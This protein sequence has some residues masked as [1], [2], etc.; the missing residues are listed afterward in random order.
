MVKNCMANRN[1]RRSGLGDLLRYRVHQDAQQA[2]QNSPG[3]RKLAEEMAINAIAKLLLEFLK[4]QAGRKIILES[5]AESINATFLNE[6]GEPAEPD[7]L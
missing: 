1:R 7:E 6:K 4:K 3:I 5:T 2:W